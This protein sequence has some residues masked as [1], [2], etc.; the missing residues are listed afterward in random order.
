[1]D[2][3][4]PLLKIVT[5]IIPV[6]NGRDNSD[7]VVYLGPSRTK[8]HRYLIILYIAKFV[9]SFTLWGKNFENSTFF[10]IY[11]L[12]NVAKAFRNPIHYD[13]T[14]VAANIY[15]RAEEK[16][17]VEFKKVDGATY[18]TTNEKGDEF[19]LDVL[20]DFIT[21]VTIHS[22]SSSDD[23]FTS[24]GVNTL[25]L[26]KQASEYFKSLLQRISQFNNEFGEID[27]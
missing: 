14:K 23:R 25:F 11:S 6:L 19:C 18:I 12:G 1:M 10:T 15:K 4:N 3:L 5:D 7:N 20:K 16:G 24:K 17:L 2:D 21:L 8:I 27:L 13:R 26:G 22:D 9:P